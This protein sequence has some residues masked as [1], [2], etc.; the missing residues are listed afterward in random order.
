MLIE[1][2]DVLVTT[3]IQL[4]L[5]GGLLIFLAIVVKAFFSGPICIDNPDL[6]IAFSISIVSLFKVIW[7]DMLEVTMLLLIAV[8][9][10][11]YKLPVFHHL[12]LA[13][14]ETVLVAA[15]KVVFCVCVNFKSSMPL[16]ILEVEALFI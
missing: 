7:K 16:S 15:F 9:S 3:L 5:F 6:S 12:E 14:F 10:L 13:V 8:D 1:V 11:F 2:T 4:Y